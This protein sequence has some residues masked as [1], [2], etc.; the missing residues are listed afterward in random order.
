VGGQKVNL[1]GLVGLL[2]SYTVPV[3]HYFFQAEARQ[4]TGDVPNE[5]REN[6]RNLEALHLIELAHRDPG[7][8][9]RQY[10][11]R[12]DSQIWAIFEQALRLTNGARRA[13]KRSVG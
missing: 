11:R 13:R 4:G 7:P 6:L 5:V 12:L 3:G 8:G 10:Y 1:Q 2:P 9:R